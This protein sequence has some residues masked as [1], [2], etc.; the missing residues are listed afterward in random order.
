MAREPHFIIKQDWH[1]ASIL[2]L[3]VC[4]VVRIISTK[5][6]FRKARHDLPHPACTFVCDTSGYEKDATEAMKAHM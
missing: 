5:N 4:I 2:G 6:R 3:S 1:Y